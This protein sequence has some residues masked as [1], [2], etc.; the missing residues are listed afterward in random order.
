MEDEKNKK[1]K[2]KMKNVALGVA[3]KARSEGDYEK[4]RKWLL[5]AVED[6][7]DGEAI[8]ILSRLY[9]LGEMGFN[10]NASESR[11]WLKK[12]ASLGYG[13][14][15]FDLP[16]LYGDSQKMKFE[17]YDKAFA[18]GNNYAVA[19]CYDFGARVPQNP[20]KALEHFAKAVTEDDC[21]FAQYCYANRIRNRYKHTQ[22]TAFRWFLRS[23]QQGHVSAQSILGDYYVGL[24]THCQDYFENHFQDAYMARS[25]YR[26]AYDQGNYGAKAKMEYL[27]GIFALQRENAR[28]A[29]LCL[30]YICKHKLSN[31]ISFLQTPLDVIKLIV[32]ILHK[33]RKQTI[34]HFDA[35]LPSI[36]SITNNNDK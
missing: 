9:E 36:R 6:D 11:T 16:H 13:P 21:M 32:Q 1:R 3:K 28:R 29:I 12:A 30:L 33:T 22:G 31:C 7:E 14:A 10:R 5:R 15:M 23:A 2:K 35:T 20:I 27:D 24:E 25:W 19:M 34:W 18:S 4:A 17:W 8:Y 26:K